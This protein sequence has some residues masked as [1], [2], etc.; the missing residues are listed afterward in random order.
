MGV[1]FGWTTSFASIDRDRGP[2]LRS[3]ELSAVSSTR[4]LKRSTPTLEVYWNAL[5]EARKRD[6]AVVRDLIHG[7]W[8][9]ARL[10]MGLN[11]PTFHLANEPFCALADQ[12]HYMVLYIMPHDLLNVFRHELFMHNHGRTCIRFKRLSP[13]LLDLFDRII[14]YTGARFTESA[15]YGK[16]SNAHTFLRHV[17]LT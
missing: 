16:A 1:N 2:S 9:E 14:K 15:H 4:R 5:P 13:E 17:P 12:K 3:C 10:D 7:I 11:M 6:L 8:P